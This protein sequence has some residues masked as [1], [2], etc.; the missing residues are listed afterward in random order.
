MPLQTIRRN[1]RQANWPAEHLPESDGYKAMRFLR[2][3][4]LRGAEICVGA[5]ARI[6]PRVYRGEDKIALA[7]FIIKEVYHI[8]N[9]ILLLYSKRNLFYRRAVR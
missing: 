4:D 5:L 8:A 1:S 2:P 7:N 6:N 9:A 3:V